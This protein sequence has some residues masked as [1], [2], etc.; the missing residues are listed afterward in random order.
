MSV[1]FTASQRSEWL[2]IPVVERILQI[3]RAEILN[4]VTAGKLRGKLIGDEPM[5][6]S[7]SLDRYCE[8]RPLFAAPTPPTYEKRNGRAYLVIE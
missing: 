8:R 3:P 6:D 2:P 5:I 7:A 1:S 4:L